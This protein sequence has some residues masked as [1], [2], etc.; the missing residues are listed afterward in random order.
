MKLLLSVARPLAYFT[1]FWIAWSLGTCF[2]VGAYTSIKE[3]KKWNRPVTVT[4]QS[5][6][7]A[8]PEIE[9]SLDFLPEN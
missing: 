1:A 2:V 9:E 6:K 7:R 3:I 4:Q 5:A 8:I